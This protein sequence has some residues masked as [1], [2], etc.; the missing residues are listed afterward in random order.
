L[1]DILDEN[2]LMNYNLSENKFKNDFENII[3][4]NFEL[5]N[6]S[7]II[8]YIISLSD[9]NLFIK[10]KFY[11]DSFIEYSLNDYINQKDVEEE[12]FKEYSIEE[13]INKKESEDHNNILNHKRIINKL[14]INRLLNNLLKFD[15]LL[16][17]KKNNQKI[18]FLYTKFD[19]LQKRLNGNDLSF[20][21]LFNMG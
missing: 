16:K 14:F 13:Y 20:N 5:I 8:F 15:E 17:N 9:D 3:K 12:N 4:S 2:K 6:N 10:N 18:I 11:Q 1:Y 19:I 21:E 7:T